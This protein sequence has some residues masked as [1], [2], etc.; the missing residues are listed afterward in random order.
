MEK[1]LLSSPNQLAQPYIYDESTK[2]QNN[3][4]NDNNIN[5][6]NNSTCESYDNTNTNNTTTT[7]T[8]TSTTSNKSTIIQQQY[9]QQP[10]MQLLH[11]LQSQDHIDPATSTTQTSLLASL[12]FTSQN[13]KPQ[14]QQ[15]LTFQQGQ[16]L[17]SQPQQSSQDVHSISGVASENLNDPSLFGGDEVVP[18]S[19]NLPDNKCFLT[20]ES[21]LGINMI[22]SGNTSFNHSRNVSLDNSMPLFHLPH[23]GNKNY[24]HFQHTDSITSISQDPPIAMNNSIPQSVSS[25]TIYSFDSV[26]SFE[27]PMHQQLQPY[28]SSSNSNS[29]SNSNNNINIMHSQSSHF[30]S[31]PRRV[32]RTKS[33]SISSYNTPMR[34]CQPSFSPLDLATAA[35]ATSNKITKTPANNKAIKGHTR[36]R[37]RVSLDAA[38]AALA[39]KTNSIS[40][41]NSTLNPF[42]TPSQLTTSFNDND[43][44]EDDDD[45][46][47]EDDEDVHEHEREN[48]F[49]ETSM[50]T[51]GLYK[52]KQS[53]STFFSPFRNNAFD[54]LDPDEN[55]AM[56]Q[57]KKAKSYTNLMRRKRKEQLG[58]PQPLDSLGENSL[59]AGA[60]VSPK[61]MSDQSS[62]LTQP[63]QKQQQHHHHQHQQQHQ[64]QH[65][66][67]QQLHRIDLLSPEFDK[68]P[69]N[70]PAFD[71]NIT[72][73]LN[74]SVSPYNQH[75][76][77]FSNTHF[78]GASINLNASI[79]LD[80]SEEDDF[81]SNINS[82]TTTNTTTTPNLLP[83]MATFSND[84][85]NFSEKEDESFELK[86]RMVKKEFTSSTTSH[87]RKSKEKSS[88]ASVSSLSSSGDNKSIGSLNENN[89]DDTVTIPIPADLH[90]TRPTVRNN[91]S[92]KNDKTDP[93][94]KHKC[95]ICESRF[96][97]PEHVKRHLKSHSSD[98]PF[99]CEEANCGK[100]FNRKDNLKAHL[101]KIHGTIPKKAANEED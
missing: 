86:N 90:V 73:N 95:P 85:L 22:D 14:L 97:R 66:H 80:P 88:K 72:T 49:S 41:Y 69:M 60:L 39:S 50:V 42:Y 78:S 36:T 26:P 100:C 7:T 77:T 38:A 74:Q 34:S 6:I 46:D 93:K 79:A 84:S 30:T 71:K 11:Q 20:D 15:G 32:G 4:P 33:T 82:S 53:R 12:S 98:K 48:T 3:T 27:S 37:S 24:H 9:Q 16:F 61:K 55:D 59:M 10:P 13:L 64:H 81:N 40:S 89:D 17:Q 23:N 21:G 51:P 99:H 92:D 96:Q 87:R 91:R 101:K 58:Q 65:L 67:Q 54:E 94:K 28:N 35:A 31:T 83:P 5:N 62:L 25:N 63:S 18:I 43:E 75:R 1:F 44:E 19:T 2:A 8:I 70:Y 68:T 52:L 29:N 45:E 56:K 47:D 57:L 76:K